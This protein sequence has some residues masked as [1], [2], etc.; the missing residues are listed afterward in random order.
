MLAWLSALGGLIVAVPI[1]F[2]WVGNGIEIW[3]APARLNSIQSQVSTNTT[4]IQMINFKMD[5][6]LKSQERVERAMHIS[7]TP[8]E[9]ENIP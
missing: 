6:M 9:K 1:V 7:P 4:E 2:G 5:Q 3:K 8:K